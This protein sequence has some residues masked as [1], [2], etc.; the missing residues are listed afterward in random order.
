MIWIKRLGY[1]YNIAKGSESTANQ[2]A[3]LCVGVLSGLP[4]FA[5]S[6]RVSIAFYLGAA[7]ELPTSVLADVLGHRRTLAFGY[8]ILALANLSLFLACHFSRTHASLPILIVSSISSALGGGLISGCL[9]AFIQNYIDQHIKHANSTT[10][11]IEDL[12][13]KALAHAQIYGN[14]F[15]ALL[16]VFILAGTLIL[17]N[18]IGQSEWALLIPTISYAIFAIFFGTIC[19]VEYGHTR[20]LS[21]NNQ[22]R[23]YQR[24][25]YRFFARLRNQSWIVRS[26]FVALLIRIT[27]ST[28]T[29]IHVHTYLLIS[30][31][32]AINLRHGTPKALA[33]GLLIIT[34]FDLA[35]I[36]KGLALAHITKRLD[37]S[38]LQY[39]SLLAQIILGLSALILALHNHA[40]VAVIGYALLFQAAFVP[41]HMTLQAQT[42]IEVPE[43]LRATMFGIIQTT[44]LI[45]YGSYSALLIASGVG[46]DAPLRIF[47]QL[48]ALA[49]T[50]LILAAAHSCLT[51]LMPKCSFPSSSGDVA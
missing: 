44:V 41:G 34:A 32:R 28:L 5:I 14:F 40:S 36:P 7:L 16:P 46:L 42:L 13:K 31:L 11:K 30:Q 18:Q 1:A 12:R 24:Q 33:T 27:F 17:Y 2:I 21:L 23:Q 39:F 9:Q 10:Q 29:V 4:V 38:Q 8:S 22:Y 50:G 47:I 37:V 6:L 19:T 3:H 35:H 15:S 20:A 26:R 49:V 48:T 25:L 45:L 51:A 43:N